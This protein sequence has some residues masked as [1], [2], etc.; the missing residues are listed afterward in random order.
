MAHIMQ[1]VSLFDGSNLKRGS[2]DSTI[3][4]INCLRKVIVRLMGGLERSVGS[5]T[6]GTTSA[7]QADVTIY[8][9]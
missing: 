3:E 1:G 8:H 6:A 7:S 4:D 2:K 9:M 5:G